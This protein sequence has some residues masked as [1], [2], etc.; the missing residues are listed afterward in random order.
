MLLEKNKML[1]E[2]PHYNKHVAE[3]D[4]STMKLYNFFKEIRN[5]FKK[6]AFIKRHQLLGPCERFRLF[7][8]VLQ[9]RKEK[10]ERI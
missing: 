1:L 4:P 10:Y 6:R 2:V 9:R 5:D 8:P 3:T 7:E